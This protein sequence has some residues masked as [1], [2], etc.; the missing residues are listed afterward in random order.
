MTARKTGKA[1]LVPEDLSKAE[2][3]A[4]ARAER[5]EAYRARAEAHRAWKEADRAWNEADRARDEAY[6]AW[7]E[8]YRVR[9]EASRAWK[10]AYRAWAEATE[11][12]PRPSKRPR[13]R[14]RAVTATKAER[15][16]A[17][18]AERDKAS[19]AQAVAY[20]AWDEASQARDEAYR[21]ADTPSEGDLA[22][23]F[24]KNRLNTE[25]CAA[26]LE[27]QMDWRA[28]Q[29]RLLKLGY[30]KYRIEEGC[31][32]WC[33]LDFELHHDAIAS[34]HALLAAKNAKIAELERQIHS[35]VYRSR[36]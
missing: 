21:A 10:E 35:S 31:P 36:K 30:S 17:A 19:Q 28:A 23:N 8:A 15:L 16:A 4:A 26:C 9:D 7:V 3:L 13:H 33:G 1:L 32:E 11:R 12:M 25:G 27:H 18:K 29:K 34:Y 2:R 24:D 22:F 20:R 14:G 5:K 6:R